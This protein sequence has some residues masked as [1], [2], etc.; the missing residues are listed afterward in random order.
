MWVEMTSAYQGRE[1]AQEVE[2]PEAEGATMRR[3]V[4]VAESMEKP[5]E[6]G[7]GIEKLIPLV[8]HKKRPE[9]AVVH[10][11]MV[12]EIKEVD[13]QDAHSHTQELMAIPNLKKEVTVHDSTSIEDIVE[14][15]H[16][17]DPGIG[18]MPPPLQLS[19]SEAPK[20]V[21]GDH[22]GGPSREEGNPKLSIQ[23]IKKIWG[24]HPSELNPDEPGPSIRRQVRVATLTDDEVPKFDCGICLETL[25]IFDI[26]HGMSCPHKFCMRCMG[27][28][29]EGRIHAGEVPILCPDPTCNKEGNGVLHPEDCK[30][31]IDFAAFCNWSDKPTENAIPPN[32]RVYYPNA[33][34]RIMLES[35]CA[36]TTPSKASCP[37]CN[38]QMCTMCGMYWSTDGS[39]QHDCAEGPE[40][41]LMKKLAIECRWKQCPRCRMLVERTGV[42]MS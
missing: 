33:K 42:A 15:E 11:A 40:A 3:F 35:T 23:Y 31:S 37:V 16:M 25:L 32:K 24:H 39:G 5:D 20:E 34:C 9:E 18:R 7:I 22:H 6:W 41:M 38:C 13:M 28:Y 2:Q 29:I 14:M 4:Q 10:D 21:L 17:V 8:Y 26:F 30:K 36:N 27:T 1:G 19:R 12:M